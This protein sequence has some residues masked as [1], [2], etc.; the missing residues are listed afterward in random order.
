M[1]IINKKI[2]IKKLFTLFCTFFSTFSM[3]LLSSCSLNINSENISGKKNIDNSLANFNINN[4]N[5]DNKIKK[6]IF[7]KP[8]NIS[9]A[10]ITLFEKTNDTWIIASKINGRVGRQGVAKKGGKREGDG[11]TPSGLYALKSGFGINYIDTNIPYVKLSGLEHWVDDPESKFYNTMQILEKGK[12]PTWNSS[13]HLIKE[14]VEYQYA[15]VIDYNNPP[16]KYKGSAIF[17]H[18]ENNKPT[19]GCVAVSKKN[20]MKI[21]RWLDGDS[22]IYIEPSS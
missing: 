18:V 19:S 15:V 3:F 7:V 11:K 4:L 9:F 16:V 5:I 14:S 10:N 13:E 1:K 12:K 20:M 6:L 17:L 2:I 22:A 21:L 8:Y